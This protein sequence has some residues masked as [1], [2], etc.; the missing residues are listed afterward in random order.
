MEIA[1]NKLEDDLKV[2][3]ILYYYND[4][5]TKDIANALDIPKGTV[6][7]R[8]KRAREKLYEILKQEEVHINE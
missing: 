3:V 6:Q 1:L 7:S 8:L 5:S 2:I 4:L